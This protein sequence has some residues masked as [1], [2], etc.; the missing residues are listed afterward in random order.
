M[1]ISL[2]VTKSWDR[3]FNDTSQSIAF[4]QWTAFVNQAPDVQLR[5]EDHVAVNPATGEK[6]TIP[7]GEG[8]SELLIGGECVPFLRFRSG[9]L[10]MEYTPDL[11]DPDNPVRDK[12][13]SVAKQLGALITHDAGDEILE[14]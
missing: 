8:E 1:G 3:D 6:I 4:D 7:A 14:W 2:I 13:S 9:N 5:T 12:I 11:D 10:V